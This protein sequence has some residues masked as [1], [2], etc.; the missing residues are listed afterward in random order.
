MKKVRC[1]QCAKPITFDETQYE[2][3]HSLVF[4]CPS[5]H[6]KFG[7]KLRPA[8]SAQSANS[9]GGEDGGSVPCGSLVVIENVFHYRQHLPLHLGDNTIG[10]YMKGSK[11]QLG[12]ESDD[13]S[14]DLLH[15]VLQVK[16]AADRTLQYILRDGPSNTGTFVGDVILGKGERRVI[17][18]GTL[19]TL[20]ATTLILKGVGV[21][22]EL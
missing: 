1:P 10:R 18:P 19:F 15:C 22:T 4:E 7:V 17:E 9:A 3:G 16:R 2:E 21:E 8:S 13:P 6:K 14:M 20:G 12:I 5:C 11:T